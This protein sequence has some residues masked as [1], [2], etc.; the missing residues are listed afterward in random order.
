MLTLKFLAGLLLFT[1]VFSSD[2]EQ[3]AS[4]AI[5]LRPLL[6]LAANIY[7]EAGNQSYEGKL[8]VKDVTL[9]RGGYVCNTVFKRKQFSWT[10]QKD[11]SLI[12][13]FLLDEPKLNK[14]DSK[15]WEE[16]KRAAKDS[17]VVLPKGYT[18]Y[19]ATYVSPYWTKGGIVI[20]NHKFLKGVN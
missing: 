12:L 8:A 17:K 2:A 15:A 18:H 7:F 5:R 4:S 14:L 16:S 3:K 10:H 11:W 19:H 6:C 9:N 20:G 1:A 13:S